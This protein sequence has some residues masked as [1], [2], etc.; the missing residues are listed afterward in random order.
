MSSIGFFRYC[1]V[2]PVKYSNTFFTRVHTRKHICYLFLSAIFNSHSP[3]HFIINYRISRTGD[4]YD[5][6]QFSFISSI[7]NLVPKNEQP[8]AAQL[9]T[10][11]ATIS[12]QVVSSVA[13]KWRWQH[14]TT[15]HHRIGRT[16]S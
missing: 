13:A 5:L 10:F 1:Y 2:L 8:R 6:I 7:L 11:V 3:N 9:P 15:S 16:S 4:S 12:T 14:E